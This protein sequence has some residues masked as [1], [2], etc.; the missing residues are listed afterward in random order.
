MLAHLLAAALLAHPASQDSIRVSA[1]L[2]D[3]VI[4][5]GDA[6]RLEV[7][8]ETSGA[9]PQSIE[10]NPL[11]AGFA[12]IGRETATEVSRSLTGGRRL[13]TTQSWVIL[14]RVPGSYTLP[15][16]RIVVDQRIHRTSPMTIVVLEGAERP[17]PPDPI[18][19]VR[20]T[21]TVE[22]GRIYVG[23]QVT[24]TA[25]AE[26]PRS[27]RQRQ[28]RPA[29][30]QSPNPSGFWAQDLPDPIV[31]GI[32]NI[33][34]ELYDTQTFRRAYFPLLPGPQTIPPA[35][36]SL[37]YRAGFGLSAQSRELLSDTIH[38]DVL[39]T[40]G[41]GKP[42]SFNGAVG[43]YS[44]QAAVDS[45]RL[46]VGEATTLI[47]T[48]S[49]T[50]NVKA[51]PAPPFVAPEGL[52]VFPPT[53]SAEVETSTMVLGG[54]KRFEWV[55]VPG[56][57]G[58][59]VIP[60]I[61]Y[62]VFDPVDERYDVLR[63][64]SVILQVT[65]QSVA[66]DPGI[67]LRPIR[68]RPSDGTPGW[69]LSPGFAL[70][71]IVPILVLFAA[72]WSTRERAAPGLKRVADDRARRFDALGQQALA[73]DRGFWGR[74]TDGIRIS[75]AEALAMPAIRGAPVDSLVMAMTGAGVPRATVS[76]LAD[77]LRS[78]DRIRYA[79]GEVTPADAPAMVD[80]A[81]SLLDA[82]ASSAAKAAP[83]RA[84][85]PAVL[86]LL[87]AMPAAVSAQDD[88]FVRAVDAYRAAEYETAAA[89]FLEHVA[90][91]PDD[92]NGWYDAG[93]A[94]FRAGDTGR[95]TAAWIRA[96]RLWPR[97][98]DAR[99]NLEM[100]SPTALGFVPGVASLTLR[101]T[102]LAL[103]GVWWMV[104][105]LAAVRLRARRRIAT[106]LVAAL[107][108]VLLV[109]L[110]GFAGVGQR[111]TAISLGEAT[112]R[113]DPALKGDPLERL[114]AGVPVEVIGRREGWLLVR[115][116]PGVEGWVDASLLD[117]V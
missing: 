15:S 85:T 21:G 14:G 82:M 114:P 44:L 86:L 9:R 43:R 57:P 27:L 95:A 105:L 17:A 64:D 104:A 7:S 100:V 34:G 74:L 26:F 12:I 106:V 103:A 38:I 66:G 2:S 33:E 90:R 109:G 117:E 51:L 19:R 3:A 55:I 81:R 84:V 72:W 61:E 93:N 59:I 65:G 39:P 78:L 48:V 89:A 30:Y 112:V 47:V 99:A 56:E 20:L 94:L 80:R 71:Q 68:G 8:V 5:A 22:P 91:H 49:G 29:T 50:G 4:A 116:G 32:R 13:I 46:R 107:A 18:E 92:A 69:V 11:P 6:V 53:E 79:P 28:T 40:P 58:R 42:P 1:T 41:D 101:E 75:I 54:S 96:V 23:Q 31:I 35:R 73:A 52:E 97:H 62:A 115:T 25:E 10:L 88:A 37:E 24:F 60:P 45:D 111:D 67:D 77:I 63:S 76:A 110:A 83:R 113:A 36:L 108:L 102:V 98:A 16:V 70:A 87:A